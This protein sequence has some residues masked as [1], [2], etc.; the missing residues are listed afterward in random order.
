MNP[1]NQVSQNQVS[2]W[3]VS[4]TPGINL[5]ALLIGFGAVW[6]GIGFWNMFQQ[7]RRGRNGM[8]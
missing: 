7:E 1:Q 4:Q 6:A 8:A 5:A 2:P 3:L